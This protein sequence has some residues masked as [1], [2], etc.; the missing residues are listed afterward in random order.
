MAGAG[1]I[2]SGHLSGTGSNHDR[3]GLGRSFTPISKAPASPAPGLFPLPGYILNSHGRARERGHH[4]SDVIIV[5][6][7]T[8]IGRAPPGVA[9]AASRLGDSLK[10][11][12]KDR[13]IGALEAVHKF[14]IGF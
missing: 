10:I 12:R 1:G 6:G 2:L 7:Q 14:R 9:G 3:P 4:L 11:T 8:I 5:A 13:R